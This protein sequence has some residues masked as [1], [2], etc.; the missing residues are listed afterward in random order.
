MY[1]DKPRKSINILLATGETFRFIDV[2]NIGEN[3]FHDDGRV[4]VVA[5]NGTEGVLDKV[6]VT[7]GESCWA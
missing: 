4:V 7:L 5:K 3:G 2:E 1:A 6:V